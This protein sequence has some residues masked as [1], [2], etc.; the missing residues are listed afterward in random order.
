MIVWT[1]I[2]SQGFT[3]LF[4]WPKH[5]LDYELAIGCPIMTT[6]YALLKYSTKN[7]GDEIQSIAARQ[8]LPKVD[9]YIDR[10]NI[11]EKHIHNDTNMILNGWFT[12]N[13]EN[14][15]I[16]NNNLKP[17]IISFHISNNYGSS[18]EKL[19]DKESIRYYKKHEPI[20]C[21]DISTLNL[22]KS[23][24]INSYFSGCLTLTLKNRFEQR[25]NNVYIVDVDDEVKQI[26]P[27][28]MKNSIK[29]LT[30]SHE[31]SLNH[32][33]NLSKA[34]SL[35]DKYAQAKMVITSRLHCALPCL[36]FGTPVEFIN[37][38]LNDPRFGGLIN[39]MR[40]YSLEDIKNGNV[41]INWVNPEPNPVDISEISN[42][43][44]KICRNYIS[45]SEEDHFIGAMGRTLA[46]RDKQIVEISSELKRT[47]ECLLSTER[48]LHELRKKTIKSFALALY[49]SLTDR[50]KFRTSKLKKQ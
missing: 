10:D 37:R 26:I 29:F 21:R 39:L 17:L 44:V 46:E 35:L 1:G 33:E 30:H 40:H 27:D 5:K 22:L 2:K 28:H 14:W 11:D 16:K 25:G 45:C 47:R 9:Y 6:K 36:A 12:H 31:G 23:K 48:E 13:P 19:T 20:G 41:N 34:Q 4:I 3:I 49:R 18:V 7:L 38:D 42:N 15:P 50:E 24:G 8:F 32:L 43:L